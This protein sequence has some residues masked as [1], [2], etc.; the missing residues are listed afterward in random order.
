VLLR[1]AQDAFL[2]RALEGLSGGIRSLAYNLYAIQEMEREWSFLENSDSSQA[3]ETNRMFR[4]FYGFHHRKASQ[5]RIRGS[6]KKE[7]LNIRVK[8]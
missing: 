6:Q 7:A 3:K 8:M 2:F 4:N 1:H 5:A